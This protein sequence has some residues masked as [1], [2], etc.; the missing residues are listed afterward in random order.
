MKSLKATDYPELRIWGDI[1]PCPRPKVNRQ[2]GRAYYPQKYINFKRRAELDLRLQWAK[3]APIAAP[4]DI[5]VLLLYERPKSRIRKATRDMRTIRSHAR[6]DVDNALKSVLDAL[7]AAGVFQNDNQVYKITVEQW[8]CGENEK[9]HAEIFLR[10]VSE[11]HWRAS[12]T[13]M[14]RPKDPGDARQLLFD[15]G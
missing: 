5:K 7:Q 11:G 10:A 9:P 2:S 15:L 8:F 12:S 3:R 4:L 6:G 13:E 14:A 1:P